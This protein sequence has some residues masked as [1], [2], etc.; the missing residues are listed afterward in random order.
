MQNV[1]APSLANN[2]GF[3]KALHFSEL[4]FVYKRSDDINKNCIIPVPL[5]SIAY[6]KLKNVI[7]I[8]ILY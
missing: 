7:E 8:L 5:I 3:K 2:M 1:L 6:Y 4:H